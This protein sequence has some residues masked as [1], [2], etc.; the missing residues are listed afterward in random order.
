MIKVKILSIKNLDHG[1][2][3]GSTGLIRV[4]TPCCSLNT[5][6]QFINFTFLVTGK[7]DSGTDCVNA[8]DTVNM[9]EDAGTKFLY[10]LQ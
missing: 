2:T 3:N 4:I 6:W 7:T 8:A 5:C 10:R 1:L 9:G